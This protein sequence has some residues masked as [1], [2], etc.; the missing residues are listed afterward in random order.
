M[1]SRQLNM[2]WSQGR[3]GNINLGEYRE[4]TFEPPRPGKMTKGPN[5]DGLR[6]VRAE[7]RALQH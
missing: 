1:L 6:R 7:P 3:G 5:T 2:V 4:M